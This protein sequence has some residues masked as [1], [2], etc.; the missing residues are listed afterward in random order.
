[1]TPL[2]IL[3]ADDHPIFRRG[4]CD[5]IE[6]DPSLELVGQA[7][8]GEEA[9]TCI[10]E[11]KPDIAILDISMPVMTGID[12]T[13]QLKKYSPGVKIIILSKDDTEEFI[14]ELLKYGI[15]AYV[16]KDNAA[17]DLMTAIRETL[18]GNIYL[19]SGIIKK[20]V[21]LKRVVFPVKQYIMQ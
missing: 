12:V 21:Q 14:N 5:V 19:S 20:V 3:I 6:T 8:N 10:A 18:K 7:A 15:S 13:R 9:L 1:M 4:L 16:T 2:R 17:D 11:L